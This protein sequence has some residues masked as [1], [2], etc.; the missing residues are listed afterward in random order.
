MGF[1]GIGYGIF[2]IGG[3]QLASLV[4]RTPELIARLQSRADAL[5]ASYPWFDVD[6]TF[7]K[8][9][10]AA[11]LV[12]AKIFHG[13]WSGFGLIGALVFAFVIGL[14]TAVESRYY[15]GALVQAFRHA[16]R[17]EAAEFLGKAAS[18]VRLGFA[19]QR[20]DTIGKAQGGGRGGT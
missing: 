13:A 19:A 3:T 2:L 5:A 15:S 11:K 20:R 7:S 12:G 17:E 4:Q 18:T 1:G 8:A 9:P 16:R 6:G 14:Y 10:T